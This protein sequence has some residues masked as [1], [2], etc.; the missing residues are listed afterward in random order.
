[1]DTIGQRLCGAAFAVCAFVAANAQAQATAAP[2]PAAPPAQ[3]VTPA[4]SGMPFLGVDLFGGAMGLG[5]SGD[6]TTEGGTD[7]EFSGSGWEV[8]GTVRFRPW[9]GITGSLARTSEAGHSAYHY[10]A[11]PRVSSGYGGEFGSRL[12]AHALAGWAKSG[13]SVTPDSGYE[14]V[15][16]AGFDGLVFLRLQF[17]YVRLP[18]GD[19]H[20]NGFRGFFGGVVP[21]CF[22][23]CRPDN[24]DGFEVR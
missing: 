12:F 6:S 20:K 16:G 8:G 13:S 22:R 17:D 21:L 1:M 3:A 19:G 10:L 7:G 15:L 14:L 23:A 24:A 4:S 2:P 18:F 5:T 11:G 9:L